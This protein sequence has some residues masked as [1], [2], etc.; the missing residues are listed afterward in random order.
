MKSVSLLDR[1]HDDDDDFTANSH[2]SIL[3]TTSLPSSSTPD[4]TDRLDPELDEYECV[5]ALITFFLVLW[6]VA[7]I[8]ILTILPLQ[9]V[10]KCAI[11]TT[12]ETCLSVILL[13]VDKNTPP[14]TSP[15]MIRPYLESAYF[16]SVFLS[17]ITPVLVLFQQPPQ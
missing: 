3:P 17:G 7:C 15:S 1:P 16:F 9:P 11:I 14:P 13:L 8:I 12:P 10:V 2:S 4:T 5:T 6:I